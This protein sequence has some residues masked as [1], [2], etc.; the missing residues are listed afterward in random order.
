MVMIT[1]KKLTIT[2]SLLIV[3]AII[4]CDNNR[5]DASKEA[6]RKRAD[7]VEQD[8]VEVEN[9]RS[10]VYTCTMHPEVIRKM[11][12]VCPK[13]KMTLVEATE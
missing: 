5:V 9:E 3:F 10:A 4:S 1:K 13:C 11:A 6:P 8:R 2:C 12:G 7:S